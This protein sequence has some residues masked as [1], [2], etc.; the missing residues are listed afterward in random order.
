MGL[1]LSLDGNENEQTSKIRK[2]SIE[3]QSFFSSTI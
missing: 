1:P 3:L 2:F